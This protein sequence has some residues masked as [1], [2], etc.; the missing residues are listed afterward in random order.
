MFCANPARSEVKYGKE[1]GA[2]F[3]LEDATIA[4]AY[5]EL[6]IAALGLGTVWIGAL[7]LAKIVQIT[8]ISPAWRPVAL[9]PIGYRGESPPST[10]RRLLSEI[11]H[12]IPANVVRAR[13]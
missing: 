7:D 13:T 2:L 3:A 11:A 1:G 10:S 9:L 4:C 5:A 12:E 6:A 8:G